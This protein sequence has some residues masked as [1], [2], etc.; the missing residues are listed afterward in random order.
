MVCLITLVPSTFFYLPSPWSP[1]LGPSGH[2]GPR[3]VVCFLLPGS[4][5]SRALLPRTHLSSSSVCIQRRPPAHRPVAALESP[6]WPLQSSS[7]P[8]QLVEQVLHK[9]KAVLEIKGTLMRRPPE[10]ASPVHSVTLYA[11]Q[12]T[13]HRCP[14]AWQHGSGVFQAESRWVSRSA[15]PVH[16]WRCTAACCRR[17]LDHRNSIL[18]TRAHVQGA[19]PW[20]V[21]WGPEDV[22]GY[23]TCK[24]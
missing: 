3:P 10:A 23:C 6:W 16:L 14:Q 7:R 13:R 15:L 22:K 20:N 18:Q 21:G 8:F 4:L 5:P 9:L 17:V 2:G 12:P 19:L 1:H 11:G 24:D